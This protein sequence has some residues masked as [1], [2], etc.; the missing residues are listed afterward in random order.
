[1]PIGPSAY[2]LFFLDRITAL[3]VIAETFFCL[4]RFR[5]SVSVCLFFAPLCCLSVSQCECVC[6]FLLHADGWNAEK[7]NRCESLRGTSKQGIR[8]VC[9]TARAMDA[10]RHGWMDGWRDG[11]VRF[12]PDRVS[13]GVSC[14]SSCSLGGVVCQSLSQTVFLHVCTFTLLSRFWLCPC[15]SESLLATQANSVCVVCFCVPCGD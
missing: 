2:A 7:G 4:C 3:F 11:C 12:F 14:V 10:L 13:V 9:G 5:V 15:P 8:L 6:V 1:V